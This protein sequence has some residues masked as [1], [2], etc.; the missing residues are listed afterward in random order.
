MLP[1]IVYWTRGG[2]HCYDGFLPVG[3]FFCATHTRL[4][5]RGS[6]SKIRRHTSAQRGARAISFAMRAGLCGEAE[7]SAS[8]SRCLKSVE[9]CGEIEADL[10]AALQSIITGQSTGNIVKV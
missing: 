7:L 10:P 6:S 8:L 1:V 4:H 3:Q 5:D 2:L 9:G